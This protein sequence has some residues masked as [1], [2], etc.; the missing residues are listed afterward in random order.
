METEITN[1][2]VKNPIT[3][4]LS[5]IQSDDFLIHFASCANIEE[6]PMAAHFSDVLLVGFSG[7][8]IRHEDG[9]I[10]PFKIRYDANEREE[11]PRY[12]ELKVTDTSGAGHIMKEWVT[13]VAIAADAT[14]AA[15]T[16]F[17]EGER[18]LTKMVSRFQPAEIA[19]WFLAKYK[20][21]SFGS[22]IDGLNEEPGKSA[23]LNAI[24]SGSRKDKE[25]RVKG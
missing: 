16:E 22:R 17:E 9:A 23:W 13:R 7:Q 11:G 3:H 21:K 12:L 4:A 25:D 20:G 8:A 14:A 10:R 5:L 2:A 1:I 19:E 6:T 18:T 24:A 15:R